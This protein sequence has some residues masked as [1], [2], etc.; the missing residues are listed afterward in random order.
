MIDDIARPR[1][2]PKKTPKPLTGVA[3][4]CVL[5][6]LD[7]DLPRSAERRMEAAFRRAAIRQLLMA[8]VRVSPGKQ[9]HCFIT[10]I[11]VATSP[12]RDLCVFTVR[13]RLLDASL[14]TDPAQTGFIEVLWRAV[15]LLAATL[16]RRLSRDIVR[17]IELHAR[18]LVEALRER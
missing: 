14:A 6:A 7:T 13:S 3:P 10:C 15:P 1:A 4:V 12:S 9:G 18:E 8:D 16:P 2:V 17:L 5:C 11:E